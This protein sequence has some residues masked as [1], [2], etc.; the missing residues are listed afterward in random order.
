MTD[1]SLD[2][3]NPFKYL[4]I[5]ALKV[6]TKKIAT[7]VEDKIAS[8]QEPMGG[9]NWVTKATL[10]R[11]RYPG[12]QMAFSRFPTKVRY[13]IIFSI[14]GL[15]EIIPRIPDDEDFPKMQVYPSR[16]VLHGSEPD[17]KYIKAILVPIVIL[18]AKYDFFRMSII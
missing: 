2:H 15:E 5:P 12:G 7:F 8:Y 10:Y 9:L 17:L 16:T 6:W 3:P 1:P 18:S 4:D 13:C 11:Y 14:S